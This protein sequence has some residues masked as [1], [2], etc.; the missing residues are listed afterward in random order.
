MFA[1][2]ILG[3]FAPAIAQ[4]TP[5]LVDTDLRTF[6]RDLVCE[7]IET[8]TDGPTW[9]GIT[10]GHSTI[11]DLREQLAALD[12]RYQEYDGYFSR[13]G[14][15]QFRLITPN[16]A[17]ESLPSAIDVCIVEN[18][19]AALKISMSVST[20]YFDDLVALYGRPTTITWSSNPPT[21]RVAFWLPDGIA[22]EFATLDEP[23]T[24]GSVVRLVY[25]AYQEPENY[26]ERWPFTRTRKSTELDNLDQLFGPP[27]IQIDLDSVIA[28]ITA[29]PSRTP[30]A[31]YAPEIR[32]YSTSAP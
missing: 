24:D 29:Q 23:T 20:F 30:T 11:S 27:S 31:T 15:L 19:V 12:N 26:R 2:F 22:A 16:L 18:T 13:E 10:I 7:E 28:T 1:V 5:T 21:T 8:I 14:M 4:N 17:T 25:L 3:A 9:N 6:P 32:Q